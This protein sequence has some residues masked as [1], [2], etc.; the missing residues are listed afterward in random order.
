MVEWWPVDVADGADG[1]K[2][3][4]RVV[5]GNVESVDGPTDRRLSSKLLSDL[6]SDCIWLSIFA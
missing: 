1:E 3:L 4:V 2:E 6:I 5:R